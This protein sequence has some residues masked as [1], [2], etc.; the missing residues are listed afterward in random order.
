MSLT[1]A[2][3]SRIAA[4]I[5]DQAVERLAEIEVKKATFIAQVREMGSKLGMSTTDFQTFTDHLTDMEADLF[6]DEQ[7]DLEYSAENAGEVADL[8]YADFMSI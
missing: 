8:S 2:K 4:R 6:F 5:H 1:F 7:R 3:R